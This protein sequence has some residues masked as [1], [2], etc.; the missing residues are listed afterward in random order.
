M[1]CVEPYIPK[2]RKYHNGMELYSTS[3]FGPEPHLPQGC[4]DASLAEMSGYVQSLTEI[5]EY[6][7]KTADMATPGCPLK[8][9]ET[10]IV[11]KRE[12]HLWIL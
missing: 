4:Q 6:I 10:G 12:T 9:S 1:G 7:G 5:G 11:T 3:Y 8:A 2:W